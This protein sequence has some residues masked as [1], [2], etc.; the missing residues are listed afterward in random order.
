LPLDYKCDAAVDDLFGIMQTVG[1]DTDTF[2]ASD[3]VP[4]L[5]YIAD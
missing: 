5:S 1:T 2:A 3:L 4:F